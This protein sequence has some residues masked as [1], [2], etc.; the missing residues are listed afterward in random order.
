M[1]EASGALEELQLLVQSLTRKV[2][3]SEERYSLLQEQ[4]E[5]LKELLTTEKEQYSEKENMYKQNVRFQN[6]Q[7]FCFCSEAPKHP[8]C[9]IVNNIGFPV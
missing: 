5:S 1:T 8:K 4:A 3:E 2:G 7:L 9:V 6:S